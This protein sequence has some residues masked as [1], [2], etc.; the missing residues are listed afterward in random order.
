VIPTAISGILG[1]NLLDVPY[2]AS[3]WQLS[4]IITVSVAFVAYT[5]VKLGWLK[6]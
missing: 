1:A 4:F 3:L 6:T 2:G 5:F